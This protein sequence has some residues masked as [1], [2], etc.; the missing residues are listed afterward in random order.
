MIFSVILK[1]SAGNS[2]TESAGYELYAK[3]WDAEQ[4]EY[5]SEPV[6]KI[7]EAQY[8]FTFLDIVTRGDYVLI[9]Y[10]RN[11]MQ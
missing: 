7:T 3:L 6:E 5:L 10:V 8:G 4:V 1:D 11:S 9:I 2:L